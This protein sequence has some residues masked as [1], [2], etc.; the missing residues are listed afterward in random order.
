[1]TIAEFISRLRRLD[2]KLWVQDDELRYSAPSGVVTSSLRAE[3]AAR[4]AELLPFLRTQ[5]GTESPLTSGPSVAPVSRDTI[6]LAFNQHHVW[7]DYQS[8]PSPAV[9]II[10]LIKR[11]SGTVDPSLL[12]Y[13]LNEIVRRHEVLRTTIDIK[14]GNPIQSIASSLYLKLAVMDLKELTQSERAREL[15]RLGNK[16]VQTPFNLTTGPLLRPTLVRLDEQEYILLV[17][18]SHLVFD[19]ESASICWSELFSLYKFFLTGEPSGIE[20]LPIQFADYTVW[21]RSKWLRSDLA[22][23][24]VTYWKR[25]LAGINNRLPLPTDYPRPAVYTQ[26]SVFHDFKLGSALTK[27]TKGI[28]RQENATTF[29]V[30][31]AAYEILL[32][33]MTGRDHFIVTTVLH[34][35]EL[36]EL[37]NMIGFFNDD[38]LLRA[39]LAGAPT[40]GELVAR[41]RDHF[42][43][44]HSHTVPYYL[45]WK[46]MEAEWNSRPNPPDQ[47]AIDYRPPNQDSGFGAFHTLPFTVSD[48]IPF[49]FERY[50]NIEVQFY[51]FDRGEQ[52][53]GRYSYYPELFKASTISHWATRYQALLS[54]MVAN[55][56]GRIS[57]LDF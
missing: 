43:E 13:S 45:L 47:V 23:Q 39:N 36:A 34:G 29:M 49:A 50:F 26:L 24:E 54:K 46:A 32:N 8:Q 20:E 19:G 9:F 52:I 17:T 33:R 28:A 2:V 3:L 57:E 1:M 4:K 56:G 31:L 30:L 5:A 53:T 38:M 51:L 27:A 11:L 42:L 40:V 22:K 41:V 55:V 7:I 21:H 44:V 37:R 12:E 25:Q 16:Q 14:A 35:R 48:D 15:A 10:P 6:P 18:I